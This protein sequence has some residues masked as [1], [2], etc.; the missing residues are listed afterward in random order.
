MKKKSCEQQARDILERMGIPDAQRYPPSSL[1][2]IANLIAEN[3]YLKKQAETI[4]TAD[5]SVDK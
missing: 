4:V 2:E 3:I 5:G 1:V